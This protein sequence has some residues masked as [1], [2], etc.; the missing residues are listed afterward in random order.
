MFD[1]VMRILV[2][3]HNYVPEGNAPALRFH[4]MCTAWAT[5]GHDVQ[6]ITCTPHFPRGIVY[7]GYKNSFLRHEIV[8]GVD[9]LRVWTYVTPN[10][11]FFKRT[12]GFLVYMVVAFFVSLFQKRPDV[13]IGTSPQ[14]FAAWAGLLSSRCRWRR[15]PFI[16]DIRDLWPDSILAVGAVKKSTALRLVYWLEHRLYREAT[17]IVVVSDAFFGRLEEKGVDRKKM[18]LIPNGVDRER[19][20]DRSPDEEFRVKYGL[21]GKF[22]CVYVG[23]IG[24]ASGLNVVLDA[25]ER[26]R[27]SDRSDIV[28]VLVG[29]GAVKNELQAEAERRG[30]ENVVF[31]GL[32]P[33]EKIPGILAVAD[34][35]LVHLKKHPEFRDVMPSKMFEAAATGKPILLGVDGEAARWLRAAGAGLCFEPENVEDLLNVLRRVVADAEFRTGCGKRGRQ[36]VFQNHDQRV[37]A[38]RYVELMQSIVPATSPVPL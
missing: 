18:T 11:G 4:G 29:D 9:V 35:C 2:F 28:F 34:A 36:Y 7:D 32:L 6:V 24:M 14:F 13:I 15:I 16:A 1:L 23:T 26:L 27:E 30:L 10:K 12:I 19:F 31:T 22:V 33:K 3:T 17:R 8:D 37:F 38:E 20:E 25:A 5:M 21:V